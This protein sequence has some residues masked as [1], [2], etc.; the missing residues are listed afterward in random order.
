MG[1]YAG[2]RVLVL[3]SEKVNSLLVMSL[4]AA[5]SNASVSVLSAF[6]FLVVCIA[7][8]TPVS[9]LRS[10]VRGTPDLECTVDLWILC[11]VHT[12]VGS[13]ALGTAESIVNTSPEGEAQTEER[14]R[15]K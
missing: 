14:R 3:T 11:G 1:T 5:G 15:G 13:P 2:S 12:E 6:C 8:L 10:P 7:P 4:A 9:L